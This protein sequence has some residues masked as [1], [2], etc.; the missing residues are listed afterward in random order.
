MSSADDFGS[1]DDFESEEIGATVKTSIFM[2]GIWSVKTFVF[3]VYFFFFL[4][5]RKHRTIKGGR[6]NTKETDFQVMPIS[7]S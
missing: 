7:K 2:R 3:I 5:H 6:G 1:P 4:S